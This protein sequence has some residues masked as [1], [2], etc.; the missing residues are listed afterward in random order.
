MN[1]IIIAH[2]NEDLNWAIELKNIFDIEIYSKTDGRF[3]IIEGNKGQEVPMYLKYIIDNYTNLP[4]KTLF[5]HGHQMSLH[6]D[7]SS[8]FIIKNVNWN[9]DKFF[10]VNRREWYQEVSENYAISPDAF[11]IWLKNNWHIFQDKLEF[12]TNGL[13]F[14]SGAQFVVDKSLILQYELDFWG[15]LY[16]WIQTVDI[17]SAI[18]SRIFE[19]TWHYIF[20]KKTIE[21]K[22]DNICVY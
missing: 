15:N 13:F 21:T 8:D 18:T 11:K 7:Y 19:Y 16:K 9:L 20:S 17:D 10:S 2:Y 14:Y 22:Y 3:N 6:Q 4:E 1:K 5:L 12:P